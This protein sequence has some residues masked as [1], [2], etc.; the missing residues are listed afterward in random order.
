MIE[1]AINEIKQERSMLKN[2]I[3][4]KGS[5]SQISATTISTSV[6]SDLEFLIFNNCLLRKLNDYFRIG[7]KNINCDIKQNLIREISMMV[8]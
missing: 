1:V 6:F 8:H 5:V 4:V 2:P 7:F 3:A